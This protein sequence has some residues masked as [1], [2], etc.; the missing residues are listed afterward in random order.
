M[1]DV[2]Q[3]LSQIE[4]G[5]PSAAEQLLPLVY[6]ELRKLAAA[7]L[8]QEKPGRRCRRRRWCMRPTCGWWMSR[9]PSIGTAAG[10]SLALPPKRCGEF[11][12]IKRARQAAVKAWWR[13]AHESIWNSRAG[14]R[15]RRLTIC[16]RLMK[17]SSD[18]AAEDPQAPL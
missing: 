5:D 16:W 17:R 2:T 9:R 8:A 13:A 11:W 18:L 6:E 7:K 1:T 4:S 15:L 14:S 12:S 3:I 10:T